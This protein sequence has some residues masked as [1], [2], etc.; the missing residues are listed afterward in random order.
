MVSDRLDTPTEDENRALDWLHSKGDEDASGPRL[1][2]NV[3]GRT[4]EKRVSTKNDTFANIVV[5]LVISAFKKKLSRKGD[6][7]QILIMSPY[8]AQVALIKHKL[9]L[10][11]PMEYCAEKVEVRT[12]WDAQGHEGDLAIVDWTRS[13]GPGFIGQPWMVNVATTRSTCIEIHIGN[14]DIADGPGSGSLSP[15]YRMLQADNAVTQ[16]DAKVYESRCEKCFQFHIWKQHF[17]TNCNFCEARHHTRHCPQIRD[18]PA[19]SSQVTDLTEEADVP[20]ERL[21]AG[22]RGKSAYQGKTRADFFKA[23]YS[24]R[25]IVDIPD[26]STTSQQEN[27][28]SM[29]SRPK[30]MK[31]TEEV[32]YDRILREAKYPWMNMVL[33]EATG[34]DFDESGNPI[35][36]S[37]C[38]LLGPPAGDVVKGSHLMLGNIG[39]TPD[40]IDVP[41]GGAD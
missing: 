30:R 35:V 24:P 19:M 5:E 31:Y 27:L 15:L 25:F 6:R 3:T 1:W 8:S 28:T 40:N 41:M 36:V 22:A 9:A 34:E 29:P 26:G 32:T 11:S 21:Q 10:L 16:Y 33:E 12:V 37:S 18:H 23:Q 39:A 2:I 20:R 4:E 17:F 7:F 14:G 13:E 38:F